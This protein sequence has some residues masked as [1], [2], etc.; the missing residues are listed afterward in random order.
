[1]V[2]PLVWGWFADDWPLHHHSDLDDQRRRCDL[3]IGRR[4][5][6]GRAFAIKILT[7]ML[8]AVH[9]IPSGCLNGALHASPNHPSQDPHSRTQECCRVC[10]Q[11]NSLLMSTSRFSHY[12]Y[13]ITRDQH[14]SHTPPSTAR[15]VCL[16][17]CS[18][19]FT[20]QSLHSH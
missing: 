13:I 10:R 17:N 15:C 18:F 9:I 2:R 8:H 11:S 5:V 19:F 6:M 1:M 12:N 14:A 4:L 20:D 7:C 16:L 3:S